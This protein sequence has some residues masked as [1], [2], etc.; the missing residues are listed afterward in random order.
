MHVRSHGSYLLYP[1]WPRKGLGSVFLANSI[2][3][4]AMASYHFYPYMRFAHAVTQ[5]LPPKTH[6]KAHHHVVPQTESDKE[7]DTVQGGKKKHRSWVGTVL[8]PYSSS[9][10]EMSTIYCCYNGFT[11]LSPHQGC[12]L[13]KKAIM[14]SNISELSASTMYGMP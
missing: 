9:F 10:S 5:R 12:P 2:P 11:P 8:R 6:S 4:K 13:L 1:T 14:W 3:Q 7:T